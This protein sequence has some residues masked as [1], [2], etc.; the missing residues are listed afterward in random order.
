[1]NN[2]GNFSNKQKLAFVSNVKSYESLMWSIKIFT[3]GV[4]FTFS[5]YSNNIFESGW[6]LASV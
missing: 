5:H 3:I 1:M 4:V 2:G 6:I